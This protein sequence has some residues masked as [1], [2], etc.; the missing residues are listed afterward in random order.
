MQLKEVFSKYGKKDLLEGRGRE[1]I[2]TWRSWYK[3]KVDSFHKYTVYNGDTKIRRERLS[4]CM[5]KKVCED[6]ASLLLNEKTDFAVSNEASKKR[7]EE[8]FRDNDFWNMAN[9]AVEK[10]FALSIG[11]FVVTAN[12][13]EVD[14]EKNTVNSK[15]AKVKISFFTADKIHIFS[16]NETDITECAFVTIDRNNMYIS[17]HLIGE[18]GN[19]EIHNIKGKKYKSGNIAFDK[20]DVYTFSTNTSKPLFHFLKPNI[21]N[22]LDINSCLG[23]SVFALSLDVLKSVDMTYDSLSNEFELGKKRIF[24]SSEAMKIDQSTGERK[25]VFDPNDTVFYQLPVGM[26]DKTFVQETKGELRVE[27]H[28]NGLQS[29]LS[30]LSEKV[31]FGRNKYKFDSQGLSTATE[32]ISENSDMFR[33]LKKHEI[34]IEKII[35][36]LIES[37]AYINNEFGIGEIINTEG[38]E[39]KFDDSI[40]EDKNTEM[41]RDMQLVNVGLMFPYEFRVKYF[42]EDIETAKKNIK[43]NMPRVEF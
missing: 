6:W 29:Q 37:I 22:N 28:I 18:N 35:R 36:G 7:I 27:E 24:V 39:V 23:I 42:A 38:I 15:D 32:V 41:I 19:Y 16:T 8:I 10:S 43:E 34:L 11:A 25:F 30:M 9:E 31:G 1:L 13:L 40:I 3:G 4:L 26:D 5:A 21:A 12:N 33:H 20:D 17:I 2:E 14:I